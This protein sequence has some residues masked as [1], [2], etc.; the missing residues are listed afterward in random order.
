[1]FHSFLVTYKQFLPDL[2][3]RILSVVVFFF[4]LLLLLFCL[5]QIIEHFCPYSTQ[6]PYSEETR[7]QVSR[8]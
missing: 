5:I 2:S 4:L 6:P 8:N 3:H 1:M 7:G